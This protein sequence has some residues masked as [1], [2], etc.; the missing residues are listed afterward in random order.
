MLNRIAGLCLLAIAVPSS[1]YAGDLNPPAGPVTA[2][3]RFGPRTEIDQANTPGDA[4]SVFKISAPGSYY[5]GGNLA[6][7]PSIPPTLPPRKSRTSSVYPFKFFC[8]T[9]LGRESYENWGRTPFSWK[10]KMLPVE[11]T[12]TMAPT[13]KTRKAPV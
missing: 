7:P 2:T 10:D 1:T 3:G 12:E 6:G 4:N 13:S 11:L 8:R 9:G 5:L